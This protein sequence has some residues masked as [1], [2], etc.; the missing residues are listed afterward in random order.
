MRQLGSEQIAEGPA[1]LERGDLE[2]L[3]RNLADDVL[4]LR[5]GPEAPLPWLVAYSPG[6][7]AVA[8]EVAAILALDSGETPVLATLAV[9]RHTQL[10]DVD[11]DFAVLPTA[12]PG[13]VTGADLLL[14]TDVLGSG[15][16]AHAALGALLDWGVPARL[17]LGALIDSGRRQVPLELAALGNRHQPLAGQRVTLLCDQH[18]HLARAVEIE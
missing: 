11:D 5:A 14:L 1:V 9:S 15:W 4:A 18:G 2:Q 8:G 12:L 3:L 17:H 10:L 13:P 16:L 6:G 7:V